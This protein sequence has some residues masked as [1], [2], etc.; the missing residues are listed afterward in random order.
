MAISVLESQPTP[1]IL[2][3]LDFI[4]TI[5]FNNSDKNGT[6]ALHLDVGVKQL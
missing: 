2:Y 5:L 6:W 3:I 4:M 1:H